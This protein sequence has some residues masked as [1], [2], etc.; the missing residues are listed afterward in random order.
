M[1]Q[2]AEGLGG[3][4]LRALQLGHR[5]RVRDDKPP[6]P[7][8]VRLGALV[9]PLVLD[10]ALGQYARERSIDL[11]ADLRIVQ[12]DGMLPVLDGQLVHVTEGPTLVA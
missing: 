10:G 8:G 9:R 5:L 12:P 6:T 2:E 7:A 4:G 11:A 1:A 3:L